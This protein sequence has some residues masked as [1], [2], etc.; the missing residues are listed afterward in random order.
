MHG[1]TIKILSCLFELGSEALE[2]KLSF[3]V[4]NRQKMSCVILM[5]SW[6]QV[7]RC[8]TLNRTQFFPFHRSASFEEWKRASRNF[9]K[10]QW[11]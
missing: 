5:R 8:T 3:V 6:V 10:L 4:L 11:K 2:G 1:A 9:I 7:I